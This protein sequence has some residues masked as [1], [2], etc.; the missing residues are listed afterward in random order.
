MGAIFILRQVQEKILK[1]NNKRYRT[2][3]NL[4]K[5]FDKIPREMVYWS[6]RK[7]GI[8]QKIIHVVRSMYEGSITRSGAGYTEGLEIKV[9]VHQGSGLSS[10]LFIIVMNDI[11]K[12]GRREVPWDMLHADDLIVAE[13]S[14]ANLWTRGQKALESK[15]LRI[16]AS[17]TEPMVRSKM[18]ELLMITNCRGNILKQV[19]T[20][21]ISDR[22]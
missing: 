4:E 15:G 10:L 6:L 2:F 21:N 5:A 17:K 9:G 1:G 19:E 22:M 8:T 12:A 14:A 16:N 20:S 3:V 11:S 18:D 13:D 7:K